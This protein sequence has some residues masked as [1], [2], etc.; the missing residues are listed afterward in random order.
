MKRYRITR[1]EVPT[2]PVLRLTFDDGLKGD[3]DL[4]SEIEHGPRYAPLKDEAYFRTVSV[5]EDGCSFGW[6]LDETF[7]EIDFGAD[8]AR[9]DIETAMVRERA[10]RF[11]QKHSHA[12]E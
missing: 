2:Y 9:I 7:S 4:S 12:A 3:L 11:R 6:R 1:I 10:D 8:G 5:A